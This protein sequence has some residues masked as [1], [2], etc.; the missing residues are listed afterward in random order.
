[1][2]IRVFIYDLV[3]NILAKVCSLQEGYCEKRCEIQS[4]S[5]DVKLMATILIIAIQVK[6]VEGNP[7]SPV[8][9]LVIH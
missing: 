2:I 6:R 3:Q 9:S 4:G 7:N 1:M 8:L 5:Q